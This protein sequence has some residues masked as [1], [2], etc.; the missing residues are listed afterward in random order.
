MQVRK[1]VWLLAAVFAVLSV[2]GFFQ[3]AYPLHAAASG[4]AQADKRKPGLYMTFQ[5]DKGNIA[6]KLYE[7]EAPVTVRTMVGLAIGKL[8]Y[9]D[10][11]TKQV[12]RKKFFEGLVFDRVVPGVLIQGGDLLGTGVGHPEGPG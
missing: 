3:A 8:S 12:M 1:H 7:T 4:A 11:Q 5:T 9:V 2:A 10:P 6:C